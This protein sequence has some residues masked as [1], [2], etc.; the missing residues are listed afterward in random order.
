MNREYAIASSDT[1]MQ[2]PVKNSVIFSSL[3]I[4]FTDSFPLEFD[5]FPLAVDSMCPPLSVLL[6]ILSNQSFVLPPFFDLLP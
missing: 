1:A 4:F 6:V 5:D 3:F 2:I